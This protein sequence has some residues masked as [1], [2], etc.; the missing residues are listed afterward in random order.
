M[1]NAPAIVWAHGGGQR[2]DLEHGKHAARYGYAM[3]DYNWGGREI[4][5]SIEKNTDWGAV[6]P[7]QGPTVLSWSKTQR[8]PNSNLLPDEHTIDPVLSPR[9]G[10]WFL[11]AYAGR[12]AITFLEQQ[13]PAVD[14]DQD[15]LHRFFDGRKY[16]LLCRRSI[17]A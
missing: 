5:E 15:R 14:P 6:D 10:N 12:R 7:S 4:V 17:H 3:I 9:N 2:A 8:E 1:K 11:L 13:S 16:H